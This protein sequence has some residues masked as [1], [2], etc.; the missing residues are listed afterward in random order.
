[1]HRQICPLQPISLYSG[2]IRCRHIKVWYLPERVLRQF[3]YGQNHSEASTTLRSC[4][5]NTIADGHIVCAFHR[6][7]LD[8][9]CAR[10]PWSI[11]VAHDAWLYD[12]V[13]KDFTSLSWPLPAEDPPK[14]TEIDVII[15][16]E[17]Q[18]DGQTVT[19]FVLKMLHIRKMIRALMVS[20]DIPPDSLPYSVHQQIER[21]THF[22]HQYRRRSR[23]G[24]PSTQWCFVRVCNIIQITFFVWI[25]RTSC[26][27][28]I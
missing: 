8:S 20:G 26:F 2:W 16:E 28:W 17:A 21:V 24:G 6:S 5:H 3:G 7:G 19:T 13:Y 14:P 23:R 22:F 15:H 12:V 9:S 4:W 1:M 27:V 11:S 18:I 25:I 10:N